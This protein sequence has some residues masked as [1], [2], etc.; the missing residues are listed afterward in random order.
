MDEMLGA[1]G[2]GIRARGAELQLQGIGPVFILNQ[3]GQPQRQAAHIGVLVVDGIGGLLLRGVHELGQVQAPLLAQVGGTAHA[4]EP[5]PGIR[6]VRAAQHCSQ[7]A[8]KRMASGRGAGHPRK[9]DAVGIIIIIPHEHI[10]FQMET[11]N[12]AL[13]RRFYLLGSCL[14][15]AHRQQGGAHAQSRTFHAGQ[16]VRFTSAWQGK[17]RHALR[18][19]FSKPANIHKLHPFRHS[20]LHHDY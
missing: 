3:G 9:A 19:H 2:E 7:H 11:D 20:P 5:P 15:E 16:F 14:Q 18:L 1:L 13:L 6:G 12:G 10:V 8:G 4:H 17:I